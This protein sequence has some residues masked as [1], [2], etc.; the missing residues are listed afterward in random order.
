MLWQLA[1][2]GALARQTFSA[3]QKGE[4]F[5]IA[6][7]LKKKV[8][9]NVLQEQ[10]NNCVERQGQHVKPQILRETSTNRDAVKMLKPSKF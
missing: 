8:F 6:R 3:G 10:G 7:I 5:A 4:L 9:G 1:F 2:R